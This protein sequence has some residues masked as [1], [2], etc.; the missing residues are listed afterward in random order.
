MYKLGV[1]TQVPPWAL[2]SSTQG[3]PHHM[4][5]TH[6][7]T[8]EPLLWFQVPSM[9]L[10]PGGC[11]FL[12]FEFSDN[13]LSSIFLCERQLGLLSQPHGPDS[14]DIYDVP[15]VCPQWL[16][17]KNTETSKPQYFPS[18]HFKS[19]GPERE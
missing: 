17:A 16:D 18:R 13:D 9:T 14:G 5:S 8:H 15:T 3:S 7:E 11:P 1:S 10:A 19:R 2:N 4:G 12:A 6:L